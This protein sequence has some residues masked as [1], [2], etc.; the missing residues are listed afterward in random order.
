MYVITYN[1]KPLIYTKEKSGLAR[2]GRGSVE[3]VFIG[4]GQDRRGWNRE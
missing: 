1:Y 3:R 4:K 2:I